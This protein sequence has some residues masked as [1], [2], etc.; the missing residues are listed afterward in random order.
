[1]SNKIVEFGPITAFDEGTIHADKTQVVKILEE[2]AEVY[3]AWEAYDR[4]RQGS[5]NSFE[6]LARKRHIF[7]ECCDVV[8][9]VA[10]LCAALNYTDMLD[11]M[12]ECTQRNI[13]RGRITKL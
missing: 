13:D 2:A 10:N 5:F 9:A 8:Q 12:Y 4:I 7:D 11:F 3:S 6:Y 1:M